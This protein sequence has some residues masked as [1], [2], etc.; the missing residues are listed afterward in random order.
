MEFPRQ[1]VRLVREYHLVFGMLTWGRLESGF[2]L[3]KTTRIP[4]GVIIITH[5]ILNL[6]TKL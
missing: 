2:G 1:P 6:D 3:G 5:I 4:N